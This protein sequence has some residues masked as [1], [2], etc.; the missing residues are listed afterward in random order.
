MTTAATQAGA[1]IRM[2]AQQLRDTWQARLLAAADGKEF[3]VALCV[4][5]LEWPTALPTLLRATFPGFRD[6]VRPFLTGYA[7]TQIDGSIYCAMI[8][9]DYSWGYQKLYDS[10]AEMTAEFRAIADKLKLADKDREKMFD[11]LKKWVTSDR[12]VDEYGRRK[13]N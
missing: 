4:I 13:L 9:R 3:A 12:R 11:L 6:I 10:Q 1:L 7:T 2:H 8:D 5:A